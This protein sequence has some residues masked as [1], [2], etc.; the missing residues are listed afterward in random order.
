MRSFSSGLSGFWSIDTPSAITLFTSAPPH[1]AAAA[2]GVGAEEG[3]PPSTAP[4]E[5][6]EESCGAAEADGVPAPALGVPLPGV[7]PPS[8]CPFS[9]SFSAPADLAGFFSEKS[10]VLPITAR[11]SPTFA[12]TRR[13]P[14]INAITQ[15]QPSFARRYLFMKAL[16]VHSKAKT[17][18]FLNCSSVSN[19]D[20]DASLVLA[21][22]A[23]ED[24]EEGEGEEEKAAVRESE[25]PPVSPLDTPVESCSFSFVASPSDAG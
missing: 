12:T 3:D 24:K 9:F 23:E 2:A 16:S 19:G 22:A 21:E 6:A 14:R 1:P 7:F 15:V 25:D 20:G 10:L 5:E 8:V 4:V 18:L 17:S 11:E 13:P